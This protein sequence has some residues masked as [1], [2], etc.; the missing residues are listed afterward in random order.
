MK[1]KDPLILLLAEIAF[2]VLTP[3]IKYAGAASPFKAKITVRHGDAD[4]PLLIVGSAHQP[5][6]DGQVIAVLNPD[7]DLES[8]IHAGCAYH[9][10][11]LK[12]IVSGKCNAM[13]MVWLDAYKRPEAGRTIL[14]SYVSRSPSAPKFK[15]E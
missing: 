12:D 8:A 11:L 2:D 13:V 3:L 4:F 6:E 5:Q 14:A 1:T 15:V 9:G 10:P 7:L